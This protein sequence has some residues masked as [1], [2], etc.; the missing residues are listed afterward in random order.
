MTTCM[1]VDIED[2]EAHSKW[3]ALARELGP[4]FSSRAT[5]HDAEDSFCSRKL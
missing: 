2:I 3:V 4:D 1:S 5:Q